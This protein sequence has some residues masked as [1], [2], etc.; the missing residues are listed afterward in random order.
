MSPDWQVDSQ[1][2]DH[3]GS[4]SFTVDFPTPSPQR[5]VF[6]PLV[7]QAS[8]FEMPPWILTSLSRT[9]SHGDLY[10]QGELKE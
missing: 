10:L 9:G 7:F 1:P 2:L 5:M 4:P 3:K 6:S 8:I